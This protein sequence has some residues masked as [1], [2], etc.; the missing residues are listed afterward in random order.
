MKLAS[1]KPRN[2]RDAK[3]RSSTIDLS[4]YRDL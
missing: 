2:G 1:K 3:R 4:F